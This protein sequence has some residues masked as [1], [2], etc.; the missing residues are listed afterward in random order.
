MVL[1][2]EGIYVCNIDAEAREEKVA[3]LIGLYGS[4]RKTRCIVVRSRFR[5]RE[6]VLVFSGIYVC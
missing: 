4:A 1:R 2:I 3:V 5:E 6:R